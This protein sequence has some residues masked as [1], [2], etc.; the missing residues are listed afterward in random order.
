VAAEL[1]YDEFNDRSLVSPLSTG[2]GLIALFTG[3]RTYY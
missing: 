1:T 2:H 3:D